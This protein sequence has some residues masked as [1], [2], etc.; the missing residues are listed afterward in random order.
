MTFLGQAVVIVAVSLTTLETRAA[1]G[2]ASPVAQWSFEEVRERKIPDS[3]GNHTG[4]VKGA[5]QQVPG[6]EGQ[7]MKFD[8]CIVSVPSSS[9]LRFTN[10]TFSIAAWVNPYTL[11]GSQQMIVAKNAYSAGQREWG[12]MLDK[13]NRFRFYLWQKGWKTIASRTEPRPGHWHHVAV[14]V[15]KGHG[16]IYI[17]G[18]Q[19]AEG[20]LGPSVPMTDALLTI[21]GVQDGRR[22]MQ[23]FVGALDE[24]ALF[25]GVLTP[26]AIRALADKQTTPHKIEIIEPVKIW[27]GGAVPKSA[28]IPVLKGTGFSVIKPYEFDKDGYRFLHG[29]ALAWHKGKLYASFG[30]N[31]GGENTDTEEARFCTSDDDGKTWSDVATMDVGDEPG[32]GVSHGVFHSHDGRLWAFHGAYSGTMQNVHTRAYVLDESSGQW[33]GR[34]TVIKGGFW[35]LQQPVRMGDGNWIMAGISARGDAAAGGRHPAAVAISRGDDV[36]KWDLVV[37]PAG[38]GVG[39]MWGE[40]G[41]IVAGKHIT[42]IARYGDHA[43]ALVA[44]SGDFGR[45]WTPSLPS[46]LPMATSKPCT[47]MLSTGQQYLI[48]STSA[49]G[50]KRRAPLTIAVSKP[51]E[52]EFSK[53]F[54]IRHAEFP[55]GPGESHSK[56]SLSYPCATEHDGKLYVGYSN[57]G[58]GVGRKGTGRELWNN[59]SAELAVIPLGALKVD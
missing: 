57:S 59:N 55:A 40:S 7:G 2:A 24:V 35:P 5:L 27:G 32:I 3:V 48:C 47:G 21:G 38:K 37:I 20:M 46:N 41:V 13:D 30:H 22:V 19:E 6:V 8:D 58:G 45:A 10:A 51:G 39:K 14:T 44:T 18:K 9:S 43:Q 56:A 36:T 31:K 29:V 33:Q 54:V 42:N 12:L 52:T 50:G 11:D 1:D 49:D 25:R 53:V 34:G 28:E 23:T 17:N 26:T 16:R 15:E 4:T